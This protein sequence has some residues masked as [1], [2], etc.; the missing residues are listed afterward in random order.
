MALAPD[1]ITAL[2]RMRL[3]GL[4][5]AALLSG[6]A[7]VAFHEHQ[8]ALAGAAQLAASSDLRVVAQSLSM[9]AAAAP[10]QTPEKLHQHYADLLAVLTRGGQLGPL[11]VPPLGAEFA[12]ILAAL[13]ESAHQQHTDLFARAGELDASLRASLTR[14]GP[15]QVLVALLSLAASGCLMLIAAI[16]VA[17][18]NRQAE[19]ARQRQRALEISNRETQDALLGLMDELEKLARGDL[20]A[21]ATVDERITG[22]VADGVN[23]AIGELRLQLSNIDESSAQLAQLIQAIPAA[24]AQG[25]PGISPQTREALASQAAT[26]RRAVER[27][28][29][30]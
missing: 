11:D 2:R 16:F 4:V 27:F 30:T 25:E 26:L 24:G 23:Y 15:M 29:L 18:V 1:R 21:R 17:D 28:K 19:A 8:R 12:P 22:A 13:Q 3:L 9:P 5:F 10:A 14:F 20:T 6:I 7:L